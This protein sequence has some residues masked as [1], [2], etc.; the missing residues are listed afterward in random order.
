MGKKIYNYDKDMYKA[1]STANSCQY[2]YITDGYDKFVSNCN[3]NGGYVLAPSESGVYIKHNSCDKLYVEITDE[4][5]NKYI[6]DR[7]VTTIIFAC[8]IIACDIGLAIF[9]FFLFKSDGSGI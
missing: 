2:N 4:V 3:V 5:E 6:Y 8:L 1:D 7:W 9:G